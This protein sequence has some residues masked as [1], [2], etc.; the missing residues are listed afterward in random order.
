MKFQNVKVQ[1]S[2]SSEDRTMEDSVT[3]PNGIEVQDKTLNV[4]NSVPLP[5]NSNSNKS[6]N[7]NH[8]TEIRQVGK[9]KKRD[10][11]LLVV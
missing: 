5:S 9:M 2:L 11:L 3:E 1:Q 7:F 4:T 6:V 10:K 8:M